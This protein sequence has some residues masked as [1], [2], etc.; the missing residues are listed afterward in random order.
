MVLVGCS[1]KEPVKGNRSSD[2]SPAIS[3]DLAVPSSVESIVVGG[4]TKET[5]R[6]WSDSIKSQLAQIADALVKDDSA[7]VKTLAA[8][9]NRIEMVDPDRLQ[10][11]E[12]YQGQ[13]VKVV[14]ISPPRARD[15]HNDPNGNG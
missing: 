10:A 1:Q 14:E 3:S 13:S 11:T 12:V 15:R 5:S 6:L 2:V 9:A 7:G 4:D 8:L